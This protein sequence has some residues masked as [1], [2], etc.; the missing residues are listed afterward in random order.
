[1]NYYPQFGVLLNQYLAK[2]DRTPAWLSRRL[3]VN[4][5][6]VSRWLNDGARPGNPETIVR[7]ADVLGIQSERNRLLVAAGYGYQGASHRAIRDHSAQI[8][9]SLTSAADALALIYLELNP[10]QWRVRS[11]RIASYPNP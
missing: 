3:G 5:G 10:R 4:G 6:T 1:M 7:I 2:L 9:N 11:H 8:S